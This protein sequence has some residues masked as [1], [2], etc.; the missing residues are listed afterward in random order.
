MDS[1]AQDTIFA[2]ASGALPAGIAVIRI[3]GPE[4]RFALETMTGPVDAERR[5]E[6]RSIRAPDGT[7]LDRGLRLW[8]PDPSSFTGEDYAELHLHGGRAVVASVLAALSSMAGVRSAE[9]GEFTLR[10][11]FNG[12]IDLTGAEALA[13]LVDAETEGQRRFA[14]DNSRDRHALL[15]DGWRSRIVD[16]LSEM[17]AAIDFADE[18]DVERYGSETGTTDIAALI[19]EIDSHVERFHAGEIIRRGFRVALIGPPNAGKSSL[20]NA[21][22]G[23]DAAIVADEPGTTRD[24]VEVALDLGGYK[25]LVQDT[26]GLRPDAGTVERIGMERALRAARDADLV[27]HLTDI[28][29]PHGPLPG[30]ETKAPIVA[31]GSKADLADP[32]D[33]HEFELLTSTIGGT[34][35]D[36]LLGYLTETVAKAAGAP[37]LIP[38]R[39]RH[40]DLLNEAREALLA[41]N[42]A[43]LIELRAELLQRAANSLGRITGKVDVEDLLDVIFSRF[44]IGK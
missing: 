5:A 41:G 29:G 32:P 4:T 31:V 19:E 22:A 40:V 15:Y 9:A 33:S 23:R 30:L 13:D 1:I 10:A 21:L 42:D 8:F 44:C 11:Y 17:T 18:E 6:L 34:G 37:E 3:S 2:L 27:L 12:R 25:I 7:L 16:L 20:L 43:M 26:A 35:L 36:Q 38:F 14:L 28:R 39:Q 24:I